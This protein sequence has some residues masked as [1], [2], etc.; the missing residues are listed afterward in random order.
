MLATLQGGS[1]QPKYESI[2]HGNPIE[3]LGSQIA[4]VSPILFVMMIIAIYKLFKTDA[5][6]PLVFNSIITLSLVVGAFIASLFMKIQGNWV[7]FA[8]PTAFVLL[9][10]YVES[11]AGSEKKWFAA[12]VTLSIT[13]LAFIFDTDP[14]VS[15]F[16]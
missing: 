13:L 3:F 4:L 1:A 16:P 10:W 5:S 8:Y 2:F 6:R 9:G 15:D 7:I 14:S 11:C 12:G